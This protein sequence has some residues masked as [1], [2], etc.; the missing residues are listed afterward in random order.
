MG[1]DGDGGCEKCVGDGEGVNGDLKNGDGEGEG[2]GEG[3]SEGDGESECSDQG[4]MRRE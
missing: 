4:A 3:E 2:E 1:G